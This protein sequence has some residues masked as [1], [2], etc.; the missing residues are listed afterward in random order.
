MFETKSR[1]SKISEIQFPKL[2]RLQSRMKKL[3]FEYLLNY[4]RPRAYPFGIPWSNS[5]QELN[6]VFTFIQCQWFDKMLNN[7]IKDTLPNT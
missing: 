1:V 2:Q 3:S 5:F 7:N 4:N 6:D